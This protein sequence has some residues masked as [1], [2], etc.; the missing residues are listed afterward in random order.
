MIFIGN[1]DS[2]PVPV[3]SPEFLDQAVVK[4]AGPFVY[5]EGHDG[6]TAD[7]KFRAVSPLAIDSIGKG[8][9]FRIPRVPAILGESG[10]LGG[11]FR[12]EWGGSGGRFV[13]MCP[14]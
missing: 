10:L 8:N 2:N 14:L 3:E 12:R 13:M 5:Q 6:I 7:G 1:P 9:A 11:G 4:L